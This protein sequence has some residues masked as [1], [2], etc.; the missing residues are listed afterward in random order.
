MPASQGLQTCLLP[1]LCLASLSRLLSAFPLYSVFVG[2][3]V[4]L[5]SKPVFPCPRILV[6][7][8]IPHLKVL[9]LTLSL[10]PPLTH[11]Y[12]TPTHLGFS[13]FPSSLTLLTLGKPPDQANFLRCMPLCHTAPL[14]STYSVRFHGSRGCF[15]LLPQPSP[16][17]DT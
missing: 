13:N 17:L 15:S 16:V 9:F 3:D 5:F 11:T 7:A 4:V 14:Q 1:W 10:L 2:G 6:H 8:F 12:L